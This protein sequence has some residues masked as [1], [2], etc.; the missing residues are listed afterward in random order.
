MRMKRYKVEITTNYT[1]FVDA[2]DTDH[3][4]EN[5]LES[6]RLEGPDDYQIE[7][8]TDISNDRLG[9]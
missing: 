1:A 8:V 4:E 9:A 2:E 5:A 7:T 3:A 6:M